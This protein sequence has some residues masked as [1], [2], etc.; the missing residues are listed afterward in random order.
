[1]QLPSAN[2]WRQTVPGRYSAFAYKSAR[3]GSFARTYDQF[4]SSP[5]A[6][7][8]DGCIS[9]ARVQRSG[10]L[11]GHDPKVSVSVEGIYLSYLI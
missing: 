7:R 1:M 6:V 8:G 4:L 10:I 11:H 2:K 5:L 9:A 3:S